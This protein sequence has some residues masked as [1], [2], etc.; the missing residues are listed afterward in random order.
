MNV[1]ESIMQGLSEAVEYTKGTLAADTTEISAT[2]LPDIQG[3]DICDIRMSLN[4]T[5]V[6]FAQIMGVSVETVEA[7]EDGRCIPNETA[8][9]KLSALQASP[10]LAEKYDLLAK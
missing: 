2:P 6:A 5:Q 10:K 1:Y 4:M 8:Q 9:S 7:W 3:T